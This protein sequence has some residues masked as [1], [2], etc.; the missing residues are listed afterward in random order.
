MHLWAVEQ[1]GSRRIGAGRVRATAGVTRRSRPCRPWTP[2]RCCLPAPSCAPGP[3]SLPRTP[4][5]STWRALSVGAAE[6]GATSALCT[7]RSSRGG[8][9]PLREARRLFVAFAPQPSKVETTFEGRN[10]GNFEK[11]PRGRNPKTYLHCPTIQITADP[12]PPAT[13]LPR[14]ARSRSRVALEALRR[15]CELRNAARLL[16]PLEPSS[17]GS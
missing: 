4:R 7:A 15:A 9:R 14:R 3:R 13:V 11:V 6:G 16:V 1:R 2:R 12:S 5:L 17:M 8:A 10:K